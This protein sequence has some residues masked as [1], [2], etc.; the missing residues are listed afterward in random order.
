M[1]TASA[2]LTLQVADAEVR[3]SLAQGKQDSE[4]VPLV[5]AEAS[6]PN[7]PGRVPVGQSA[8]ERVR[9]AGYLGGL[10]EPLPELPGR[11]EGGNLGPIL[12]RRQALPLGQ[13]LGGRE[14]DALPLLGSALGPWPGLSLGLRGLRGLRWGGLGLG[15]RRLL[16]GRVG[17]GARLA[18]LLGRLAG[19]GR[20]GRG[21]GRR[22][23]GRL[24]VGAA[25]RLIGGG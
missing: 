25:G 13:L 3:T 11:Q 20:R 6:A 8:R 12:H 24:V 10:A 18:G 5:R 7:S 21:A 1:T 17:R 2:T 9:G 16:A 19:E 22:G 23:R 4:N 15:R 14:V